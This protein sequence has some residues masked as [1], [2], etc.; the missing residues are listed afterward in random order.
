MTKGAKIGLTFLVAVLMGYLGA[1]IPSG[2]PL[3]VPPEPEPAY[4]NLHCWDCPRVYT[5]NPADCRMCCL[6]RCRPEDRD[7]C[8]RQCYEI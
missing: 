3:E 6:H 5:R 2:V 7:A 8:Q 4:D 1:L